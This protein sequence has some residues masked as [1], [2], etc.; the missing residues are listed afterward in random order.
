M[1]VAPDNRPVHEGDVID[2]AQV[3]P[4]MEGWLAIV[5]AVVPDPKLPGAFMISLDPMRL[6]EDLDGGPLGVE[7]FDRYSFSSG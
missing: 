4:E 3:G 1:I 7:L 6:V 2:L 5:R